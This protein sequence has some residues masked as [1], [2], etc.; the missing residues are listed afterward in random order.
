ML[1]MASEHI[2]RHAGD[3]VDLRVK[4]DFVFIFALVGHSAIQFDIVVAAVSRG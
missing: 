2:Q 4:V 1:A 3:K